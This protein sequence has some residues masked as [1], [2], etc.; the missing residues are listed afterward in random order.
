M[1]E[2]QPPTGINSLSLQQAEGCVMTDPFFPDSVL[3]RAAAKNRAQDEMSA[4]PLIASRL[5]AQAR[6]GGWSSASQSPEFILAGIIIRYM[7][8]LFSFLYTS[9]WSMALSPRFAP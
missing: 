7:Q 3:F 1:W 9:K 8:R 6:S 2:M 4:Q 5:A